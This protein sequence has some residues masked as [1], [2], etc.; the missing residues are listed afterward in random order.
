MRI[1]Y[2]EGFI[3]IWASVDRQELVKIFAKEL[4]VKKEIKK[5]NSL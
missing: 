5:E 2:A 3:Q 4:L 1:P